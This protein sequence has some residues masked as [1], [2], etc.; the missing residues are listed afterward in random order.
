MHTSA[1][2]TGLTDIAQAFLKMQIFVKCKSCT[3]SKMKQKG[4]KKERSL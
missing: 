4:I 3:A 2:F 1:Y